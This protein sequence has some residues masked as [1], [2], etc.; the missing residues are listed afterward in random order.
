MVSLIATVLK[1]RS[2]IFGDYVFK[3]ELMFSVTPAATEQIAAYF[4]GKS[5]RP[6]RIFL[7]EG[8]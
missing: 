3:E 5:V 7:N 8:G 2:P 4:K 1:L 6:I